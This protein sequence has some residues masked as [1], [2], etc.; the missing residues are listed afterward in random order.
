M[1]CLHQIAFPL[2]MIDVGNDTA[3]QAVLGL[4]KRQA[5]KHLSTTVQLLSLPQPRF[6]SMV[7]CN[8]DL[9]AK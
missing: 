3:G 1:N 9:L 5:N 6:P 4:I 8:W 7:G 2:L